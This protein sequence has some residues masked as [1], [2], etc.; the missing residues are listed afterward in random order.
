MVSTKEKYKE[1]NKRIGIKGVGC[2]GA[3]A[4]FIG[5]QNRSQGKA[6]F[7]QRFEDEQCSY[8]DI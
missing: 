8:A 1:Q 4:E 5:S 2:V 6:R 3:E 7:Q